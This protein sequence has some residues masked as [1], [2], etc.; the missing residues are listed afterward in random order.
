MTD[1]LK[2]YQK[3]YRARMQRYEGPDGRPL[4]GR[5]HSHAS[6]RA[7]Y[8]AIAGC[9]TLGDFRTAVA[10]L[11]DKNAIALVKD[12]QK[13]RLAHYEALQE[14]VRALGPRRILERADSCA[15]VNALITMVGEE[16]NK[17]SIEISCDS[18]APFDDLR[19]LEELEAAESADVP[20]AYKNENAAWAEQTRARIRAE[21]SDAE[22]NLQ[23]CQPDWKFDFERIRAPRHR[24]LLPIPDAELERC[25]ATTRKILGR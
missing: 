19:L 21:Y 17:N 4:P 23:R 5:E 24:R 18:I 16:E 20:G 9:K 7:L 15:D 12:Q 6:E 14:D 13:L 1:Y 22:A 3:Y 2:A 25:I 10:D 11:P 8:E